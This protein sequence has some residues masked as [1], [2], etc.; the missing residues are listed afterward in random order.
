VDL[1]D[2]EIRGNRVKQVV[3]D[4][5]AVQETQ[6]LGIQDKLDKQEMLDKVLLH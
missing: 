5:Q 1:L 3:L 6:L 2:R 4:Q